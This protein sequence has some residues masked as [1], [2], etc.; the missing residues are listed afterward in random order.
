[1]GSAGSPP[2]QS[3]GHAVSAHTLPEQPAPK[4][5]KERRA[6]GF[7]RVAPA[8]LEA[9]P[10]LSTKPD[11]VQCWPQVRIQE[12]RCRDGPLMKD[13]SGDSGC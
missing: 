5:A 3:V 2:L 8:V 4:T 1:M 12:R 13:R 11:H 10:M 6:A 9:E 7:P